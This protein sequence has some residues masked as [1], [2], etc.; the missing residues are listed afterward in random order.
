MGELWLLHGRSKNGSY[1]ADPALNEVLQNDEAFYER[2]VH[3]AVLCEQLPEIL[4][5]DH[6]YHLLKA[7]DEIACAE[8][9]PDEIVVQPVG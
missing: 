6:S 5:E 9:L 8:K 3:H 4:A 2:L 7:A 1:I